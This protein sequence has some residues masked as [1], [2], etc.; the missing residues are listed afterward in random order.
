MLTGFPLRNL[1]G[2][3]ISEFKRL[4][5]P[6]SY[7]FDN[8]DSSVFGFGWKGLIRKDEQAKVLVSSADEKLPLATVNHFGKGEVV[9]V[10]SLLGSGLSNGCY[11]L[12]DWLIKECDLKSYPISFKSFHKDLIMKEMMTKEGYV[13]VAVNKSA[14][15]QSIELNVV[16]SKLSPTIIFADKNG[17]VSSNILTIHPDETLVVLWKN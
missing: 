9:W 11:S 4:E 6:Y 5:N 2:G 13:T 8:F 17:S 1:F 10:P 15:T 16:D 14:S 3:R 12:A 7:H